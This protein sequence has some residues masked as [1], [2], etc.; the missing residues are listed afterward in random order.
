[1]NL[2]IVSKDIPVV[3][4]HIQTYIAIFRHNQANS[5]PRTGIFPSI[6]YH[7]YMV[8]KT[9]SSIEFLNSML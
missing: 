8:V 5:G 6:F 1:M 3:F 4:Q 7:R 2:L 9:Q